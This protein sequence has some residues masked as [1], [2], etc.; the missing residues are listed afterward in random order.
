LVADVTDQ[1]DDAIVKRRWTLESA[2][3]AGI[4]YAVAA[5]AS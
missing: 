3:I 2:A 5:S 1:S 4:V